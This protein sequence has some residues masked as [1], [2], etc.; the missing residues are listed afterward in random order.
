MRGLSHRRRSWAPA[1]V[2]LL[3]AAVAVA[4]CA[5][6]DTTA[7]RADRASSALELCRGHGG[8]TAFDDDAV[9]CRD[10]TFRE[11]RGERAVDACRDHDGVSAFD[12]DIVICLDQTFHHVEGG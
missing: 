2:T 1:A 9:I 3:A 7:D 6:S 5:S 12:D 10:E 8:V 11:E 4:G